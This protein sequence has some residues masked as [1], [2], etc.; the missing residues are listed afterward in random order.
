MLKS[1]R[2]KRIN[3]AT[4]T[5]SPASE[6]IYKSYQDCTAGFFANFSFLIAMNTDDRIVLP[7]WINQ[8]HNGV[9]SNAKHFNYWGGSDSENIF[10]RYFDILIDTQEIGI[11]PVYNLTR[12][13]RLTIPGPRLILMKNNTLFTEVRHMYHNIYK[14][15]FRP[16]ENIINKVN[17]FME[18]NHDAIAVHVRNPVHNVE[19]KP[20]NFKDYFNAINAVDDGKRP[21]LLATDNELSLL[22][23]KDKYGSRLVYFP[24]SE[25]SSVDMHIEWVQ[26]LR[27]GRE[28]ETGLINGKGYE[29]HNHTTV[30]QLK[31]DI[32]YDVV[33]E[34]LCL[35]QAAHF[36][37]S[38]SNVGLIAAIM[39]P[40]LPMTIL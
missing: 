2:N 9:N 27:H 25:R 31:K 36:I 3:R 29:L 8:T 5:P 14:R 26:A 21:I 32:A 7:Y 30:K 15:L 28:D 40:M 34:M 20:V 22:V 1:L 11:L 35:Q 37:G 33:F 10:L 24:E 12:D 6:H 13:I 23:F 38:V 18:D 4:N 19:T 17:V 16:K 39:N